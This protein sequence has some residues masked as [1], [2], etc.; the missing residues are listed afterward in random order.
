MRIITGTLFILNL[1][2][3]IVFDIICWI[4][5]GGTLGWVVLIGILTFLI[6]WGISGE[7][8]IAPLDYL[9]QPEW[10]IFVKKIKWS[11]NFCVISMAIFAL[12]CIAMNWLEFREFLDIKI[13]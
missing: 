6:S 13:Q 8:V 1:T 12:I 5:T 11:N 10:D 7:A 3:W 4:Y 9:A 2:S